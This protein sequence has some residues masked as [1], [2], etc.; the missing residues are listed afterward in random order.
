MIELNDDGGGLVVVVGVGEESVVEKGHTKR[1][2]V[3]ISGSRRRPETHIRAKASILRPPP[4]IKKGI[5]N[6]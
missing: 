3:G 2:E 4:P 1:A 5:S 6:S